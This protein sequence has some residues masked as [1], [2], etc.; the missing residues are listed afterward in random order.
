MKMDKGTDHQREM[1]IQYI[2][3]GKI[4]IPSGQQRFGNPTAHV[5]SIQRVGLV[6][7][8][9]VTPRDSRYWVLIGLDLCHACALLGWATIPAIVLSVDDLHAELI[10]IDSNLLRE[11][12]T[13]WMQGELR[14]R[15]RDICRAIDR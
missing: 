9:V 15:R 4:N 3:M 7:P 12:V 11:Q 2:P 5:A 1:H 8:I 13:P 10:V 6:Q 14:R